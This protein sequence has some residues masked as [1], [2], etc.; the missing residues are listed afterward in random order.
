MSDVEKLRRIHTE[1]R[2]LSIC[3]LGAEEV[4]SH[5]GSRGDCASKVCFIRSIAAE[6]IEKVNFTH[7]NSFVGEAWWNGRAL[8]FCLAE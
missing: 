7:V 2:R 3:Y 1:V 8:F 4:E 6:K 5:H